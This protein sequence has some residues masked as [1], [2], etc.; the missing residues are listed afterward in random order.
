MNAISNTECMH[1]SM[2]KNSQCSAMFDLTNNI[3][4]AFNSLIFDPLIPGVAYIRV[5][6]FY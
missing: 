5:F 6:I 3:I 4:S 1:E 2:E